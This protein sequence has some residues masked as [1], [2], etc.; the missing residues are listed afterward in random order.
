MTL[1]ASSHFEELY[2]STGLYATKI[3]GEVLA[4]RQLLRKSYRDNPDESLHWMMA[5]LVKSSDFRITRGPELGYVRGEE[6]FALV[7]AAR[8]P[9]GGVRLIK[10]IGDAVLLCCQGLRPL[11]EIGVLMTL[12][13][14]QLAYTA[15][16]VTYPFDIRIG[17]DFG[18]AKRLSGR[19]N[20]DYLGE[21]IDRL[22]RI[23]TLKPGSQKLLIGE[24]A[25]DLNE[26]VIR[27]YGQTFSVSGPLELPLPPEKR[28]VETVVY[29][30][31]T[32]EPGQASEFSDRFSEWKKAM[33]QPGTA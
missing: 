10:E 7:R 4:E 3:V 30:E 5:D 33:S 24:R 21:P 22:A 9:Y 15:N 14:R 13:A 16:E 6:F 25:Y 26:K 28:L 18:L 31:L 20:E 2:M 27:E 1:L 8:R 29:R 23:M 17:F 32:V 12:A 11:L 19:D